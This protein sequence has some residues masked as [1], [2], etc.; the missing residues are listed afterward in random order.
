M[1]VQAASIVTEVS[2]FRFSDASS[3][4]R[5]H[6]HHHQK[7]HFLPIFPVYPP[8]SRQLRRE[9]TLHCSS[10][11]GL[12]V[13]AAKST[14][15]ESGVNPNLGVAVYKPKSYEVLVSDAATSLFYALEDG[16]NRLEIEFP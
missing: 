14:K 2:E 1:A 12:V 10:K 11:L 6:H 3:P 13:R 5:V 8:P 4:R 15:P 16:K 9:T 7:T